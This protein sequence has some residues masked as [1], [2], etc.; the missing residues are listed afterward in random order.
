[1]PG[2]HPIRTGLKPSSRARLSASLLCVCLLGT[3]NL[4][5]AQ[6]PA[7][8]PLTWGG[9]AEGGAPYQFQDPRDPGR[10]IGFEVDIVE[11]IGRILGRRTEFVQ[12]Q[13]EGLVPGLERGNYDIIVSGLEI[14]PD[15]AE[16]I[17][18][19]RPYYP[20]FEQLTVRRGDDAIHSLDDCGGRKVG[21]LRGSL[22]QRI[23]EASKGIELR[24]YD[25]Q[26][27]AYEDLL[28]GRL[29]AVLM[30]HIIALYNVA[31]TPGLKMVGSPVGRLEYGIG[32][33]KEDTQLLTLVN[34]ALEQMISSGELRRILERWGI[35]TQACAAYFGDQS[36]GS[37]T[38]VA[39]EE[40]L[41][42]RAVERSAWE[43]AKQYAGYLPLL[44]RGAVVT[45]ELSV[46][47]MALAVAIGLLIALSRLYATAPVRA[48][49]GIYIE[50]IRGTPLLI[51]LFLIFYG[52][53]HIGIRL[54][55]MLAAVSGL[56]L[57]YSA[58]EAENY[59]A[60][61]QS[62]PRTQ[63][64]AALALGMTRIQALRYV[65]VPQAMR[66]VIPPVTNDFIALLKDSSLVSVITMVE[67]TK[68][69][70]QLASI[71]Y[72]Y[73]GI[74]LLAAGMYFLIGLPFVRLARLAE[75]HFNPEHRALLVGGKQTQAG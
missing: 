23:L 16:V 64:E 28:N 54:S 7:P 12:N 33:R 40:Y 43:R 71:H 70:S 39:F 57:N 41:G 25:G 2:R 31:P 53:P 1:L 27:N 24:S 9:D 44:G 20:T 67:L 6:T 34:R 73:L 19:S 36:P 10:I 26:I 69:Y 50:S 14:T 13:W 58:Y 8:E 45:L 5:L 75:R 51:Q 11:A 42:S 74:G 3:L 55:P 18:F 52:L 32:V 46:L 48:L 35:W 60:G 38:P 15:R 49:A 62:I 63:M 61:I 59:R 30:D 68:S 21:T 22:A 29:D 65:I 4:L 47:A 66:L 72:D 37:Q 56:A 17:S